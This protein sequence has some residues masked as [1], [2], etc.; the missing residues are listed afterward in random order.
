MVKSPEPLKPR[1]RL[2]KYRLVR[3][4][5]QGGFANVYEALDTIEGIRVALKIPKPR[6]FGPGGIEDF[7]REVRVT[8][9]LE[10]PHILPIK[11]ADVIDDHFVIATALGE[12]SLADRT[13]RRLATR[14]LLRFSEQM[15]EGLAHAHRHHIIHCDIKPEN[16]I[17]FHRDQLRLADFGIAKVALRTRSASNSG[18]LGY[19]APEQAL[20][21][22][23]RGS[24]VFSLGLVIWEMVT[25]ELPKWPFEWPPP[26][27]RT[28]RRRYPPEG[29]EILRRA[30]EID[31][32]RR[33][34]HAG[35][36]L[37]AF[38]NMKRAL[39]TSPRRHRRWL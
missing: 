1:Q 33:Y 12:C 24:D 29:I 36:M 31:T 5:A 37:Q 38:R 7:R 39:L 15:L 4:I 2:G 19:L 13:K 20:G 23:S 27:F 18:T 6:M 28:M 25:H 8:A 10:H 16:F 11:N 34:A 32:A 21:R 14:S 35:A 26:G 9:K 17:L 3:R 30:L 22:P